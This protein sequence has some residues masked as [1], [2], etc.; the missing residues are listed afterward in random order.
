MKTNYE[1]TEGDLSEL[2]DSMKTVPLIMINIGVSDSP[3][4]RANDA[5]SR[6][7]KRMGF[8]HMTV[9]PNGKGDRFFSADSLEKREA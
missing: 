5:W 8:D 3:Q 9:K 7:G 6:L 4:S 2:L 1:M